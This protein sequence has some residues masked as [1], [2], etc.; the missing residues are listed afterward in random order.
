MNVEFRTKRYDLTARIN[1][2]IFQEHLPAFTKNP[3][4]CSPFG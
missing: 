4:L 1:L 2:R 3:Y